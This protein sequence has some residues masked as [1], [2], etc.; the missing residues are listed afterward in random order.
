MIKFKL[1]DAAD[2]ATCRGA[3]EATTLFATAGFA[4]VV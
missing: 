3:P 2:A 4:A 1:G